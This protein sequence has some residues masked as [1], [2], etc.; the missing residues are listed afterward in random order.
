MQELKSIE[1][2]WKLILGNKALLPMLWTMFP[3]HPNLLPAYYEDPS[4]DDDHGVMFKNRWVSKPLYGR[5][6]IGV[7]HSKNY[8]NYY[9]FLQASKTNFGNDNTGK[10]MGKSIIQLFHK[11]PTAQKRVIQTSSWVIQGVPAGINF[12]EGKEGTDFMDTSPFLPHFVD[13]D[14]SG[15]DRNL[16]FTHTSE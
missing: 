14:R 10:V 7:L 15:Y 13:P 8:T 4:R 5:E 3:N 12:R 9:R 1:P 16:K 2:W 11:L 6:G